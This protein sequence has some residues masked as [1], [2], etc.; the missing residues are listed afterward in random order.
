MEASMAE[1]NEAEATG[2][3]VTVER[4]PGDEPEQKKKWTPDPDPH[5]T[6]GI[7]AGDNRIH[8]LKSTKDNAWLIRFDKNPNEG[9]DAEGKAY[10]KDNPHPVLAYLKSE[11]YRWAWSEADGGPAWG[12]HMAEGHYTYAEHMDARRVLA[13]AAE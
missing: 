9:V 2:R 13:K 8:L 12:K 1:G 10:S 4:Q 7:K 6:E 3:T 11:G 5:G